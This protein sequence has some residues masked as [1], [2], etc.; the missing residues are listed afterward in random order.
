MSQNPIN[1]ALRFILELGILAALGYW[2]WTRDIGPWRYLLAIA[3]PVVAAFLWGTFRWPH[4][5]AGSPR[6]PVPV[7]GWVRLLMEV[8]LFS[9][10]IA[11]LYAAG[12]VVAA[13]V[14]GVVTLFH[15]IISYDRIAAMLRPNSQ[16]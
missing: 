9:L 12:A 3:L 13:V 2:G 7:P 14:F 11:C 5:T 15:Y 4:E 8:V 1:L 10:A 6:A 16:G